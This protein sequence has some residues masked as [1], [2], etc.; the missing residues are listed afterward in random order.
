M[1]LQEIVVEIFEA[2]GE[3]SELDFW[4]DRDSQTVNTSHLGWKKIVDVVNDG[5]LALSMWKWPNGR[6]VRFRHL[7]D[8]AYMTMEPLS[9]TVSGIA[10]NSMV[11]S[12]LPAGS[13]LQV[14]KLV[15][16]STSGAT[17]TIL[18]SNGTSVV[19]TNVDGAFVNGE[20]A[21]V[22]QREFRFV[23]VSSGYDPTTVGG[24]PYF[25]ANGK[26]L[27]VS[28]VISVTDGSKLAETF[29]DSRFLY[30]DVS[31]GVPTSMYR[32]AGG[33]AVD[34]WPEKGLA[35]IVRYLRGPKQLGYTDI[36][37][38]PE[39]PVQFHRGLV[40]YGIWWGLRRAQESADAYA[41]KRDLEDFMQRTRTEFDIHDD[42]SNHQAFMSPEGRS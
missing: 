8:T 36:A 33:F 2:L 27:E 25:A 39:V 22:Y 13:N 26:P 42:L 29:K 35:Y 24:I 18:W 10:G 30:A 9:G 31:V 37:V 16:G 5:C 7:E 1:T 14:G 21:T 40:L 3:P 28:Q 41:T 38:E 20:T 17:G 12:G 6:Q 34:V 4:T 11:I 32:I 19:L 15:V 23:P